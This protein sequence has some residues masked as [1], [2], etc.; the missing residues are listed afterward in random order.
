MAPCPRTPTPRRARPAPV[1]HVARVGTGGVGAARALC[2]RR[3]VVKIHDGAFSLC[4]TCAGIISK[5]S[6]E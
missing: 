2:N 5:K 1:Q 6:L 3:V 4:Q